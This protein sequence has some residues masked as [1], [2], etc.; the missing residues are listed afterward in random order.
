ML[1]IKNKLRIDKCRVTSDKEK[2]TL[3]AALAVE[4]ANV[5]LVDVNVAVVLD[6]QTFTIPAGSFVVSR[7]KFVCKDANIT[8]GGLA[9][10]AYDVNNC[11]FKLTIKETNI[12]APSGYR[13]LGVSFADFN[14][15]GPVYLP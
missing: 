11:S 6:T 13:L 9:T 10:G 4:D 8:E 15:T 12:T 1:G 3:K 5:N 7:N 2:L 14:E